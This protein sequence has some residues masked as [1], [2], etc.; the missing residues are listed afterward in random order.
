MYIKHNYIKCSI[1][2]DALSGSN[3]SV[4]ILFAS[5]QSNQYFLQENGLLYLYQVRFCLQATD[6]RCLCRCEFVFSVLTRPS[7]VLLL[8]WFHSSPCHGSRAALPWF[9]WVFPHGHRISHC[10]CSQQEGNRNLHSS[11]SSHP[12]PGKK[13][14]LRHPP[15]PSRL[16]FSTSCGTH[17]WSCQ[18]EAEDWAFALCT[19]NSGKRN[20]PLS[21]RE[22]S[23]I[24]FAILFNPCFS[25]F[26]SIRYIFSSPQAYFRWLSQNRSPTSISTQTFTVRGK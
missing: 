22:E 20:S 15:L 21:Q 24:R 16:P 10:S 4:V 25:F 7:V 17:S 5:E 12:S 1:N 14:L 26:L 9:S 8:N 3:C 2:A 18:E 6:H 11:K 23:W 19:H 13:S